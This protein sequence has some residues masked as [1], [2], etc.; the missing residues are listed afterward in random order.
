LRIPIWRER[1][2]TDMARTLAMARVTERRTKS[3]MM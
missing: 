1:W 2:T 3:W